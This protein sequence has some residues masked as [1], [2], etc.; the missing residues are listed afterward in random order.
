M[1]RVRT[2]VTPGQTGAIELRLNP[3][4]AGP[5]DILDGTANITIDNTVTITGGEVIGAAKIQAVPG[6]EGRFARVMIELD[7]PVTG[8]H[9]LVFVFYCERGPMRELALPDT[10][11]MDSFEFDQWQFFH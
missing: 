5:E 4:A 8:V 10:R 9:D 7:R 2:P 1:A 6:Q 3:Q 11:H